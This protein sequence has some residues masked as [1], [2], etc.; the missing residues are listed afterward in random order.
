[1]D[2]KHDMSQAFSS[3]YALVIRV[4][5]LVHKWN[6]YHENIMIIMTN[7]IETEK[8]RK[9]FNFYVYGTSDQSIEVI[10]CIVLEFISN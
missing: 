9:D 8:D 5:C 6:E 10:S 7:H 2:L 1:M 4:P 3:V